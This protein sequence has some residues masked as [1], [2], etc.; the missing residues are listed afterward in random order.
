MPKFIKNAFFS[1]FLHPLVHRLLQFKQ[2]ELAFILWRYYSDYE[3]SM[4][5][6]TLSKYTDSFQYF[7]LKNHDKV[8][9][10]EEFAELEK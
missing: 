10:V 6:H 3:L 4:L 2:K 1:A 7:V 5:V 8:K 9:T